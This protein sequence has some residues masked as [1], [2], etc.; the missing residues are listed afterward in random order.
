MTLKTL[1]VAISSLMLVA[2]TGTMASEV[3]SSFVLKRIKERG[4]IN[5]G[6]REA[7][8][9]FA[10]IGKDGSPQGYSIDHGIDTCGHRKTRASIGLSRPV[11]NRLGMRPPMSRRRPGPAGQGP[12]W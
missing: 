11:Y 2:A 4:V 8:V 3:D 5:M 10:F 7:S 1:K 12:W 6:H 9:P